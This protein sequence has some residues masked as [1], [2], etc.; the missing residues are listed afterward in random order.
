MKGVGA[1]LRAAS[2]ILAAVLALLPLPAAADT[3]NGNGSNV[4]VNA[5]DYAFYRKY[6]YGYR[7]SVYVGLDI[8]TYPAEE[9]ELGAELSG[10]SLAEESGQFSLLG[11]VDLVNFALGGQIKKNTY[12]GGPGKIDYRNNGELLWADY[13][14]NARTGEYTYEYWVWD[15]PVFK[16]PDGTD[17]DIF[18]YAGRGAASDLSPSFIENRYGGYSAVSAVT[19]E[20]YF[21][22]RTTLTALLRQISLEE[23]G[24]TDY[25]TSIF[26]SPGDEFTFRLENSEVRAG[27]DIPR[28]AVDPALGHNA[29]PFVVVYE[30]LVMTY[31]RESAESVLFTATEYGLSQGTYW[32]WF[33]TGGN[34]DS[35]GMWPANGRYAFSA[36]GTRYDF[37]PLR[38]F[39]GGLA[40]QAVQ[41]LVF[42][43]LP[44]SVY[45]ETDWFGHKG[46]DPDAAGDLLSSDGR[47]WSLQAIGEYGGWGMEFFESSEYQA[48]APGVPGSG[49]GELDLYVEAVPP[50]AG[51]TEGTE[52]VSAFTVGC[53]GERSV[54]PDD[55]VSVVIT[56]AEAGEGGTVAASRRLALEALPAGETSA[57]WLKWR[58]PEGAGRRYV[59]SAGLVFGGDPDSTPDDNSDSF[60]SVSYEAADSTVPPPGYTDAPGRVCYPPD[61]RDGR[62]T[63]HEW[64]YDPDGGEFH[65][66]D[67]TAVLSA[68]IDISPDPSIGSTVFSGGTYTVRSGYGFYAAV[69]AECSVTAVCSHPYEEPAGADGCVTG[70]QA[71]DVMFP[72]TGFS[73]AF[74]E[75]TSAEL[76]SLTADEGSATSGFELPQEPS[77]HGARM[78]YIPLGYPDGRGVYSAA[79]GVSECWTPAGMISALAVSDAWN[80]D[81]SLY[82]DWYAG[83]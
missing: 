57:V 56:A 71:A 14:Y 37:S 67:Y 52:V 69:T 59:I 3:S 20:E 1:F 51:Y 77:A 21:L 6:E 13:T 5:A 16:K 54:Y 83:R 82:D 34:S 72:E 68:R 81:G 64:L 60:E 66:A 39:T 15:L 79:A 62:A 58:V 4:T 24:S 7:V 11:R 27:A 42:G 17:S 75:Y 48:P 30:P 40:G 46:F 41:S 28:S 8:R 2:A 76:M 29:M 44:A 70:A 49:D 61:E 50:N 78:H 38:I 25:W 45:L 47:W 22:S 63:W 36:G 9:E 33:S 55:D 10:M 26:A 43:S 80:I 18:S 53:R 35:S 32:N 12:V 31:L 65:R 19:P 73:A 74:G 23:Y